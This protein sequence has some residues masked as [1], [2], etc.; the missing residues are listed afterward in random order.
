MSRWKKWA[1]LARDFFK[2]GNPGSESS[3]DV[4]LLRTEDK[5]LIVVSWEVSR[6]P[7]DTGDLCDNG[8]GCCSSSLD[9]KITH[10]KEI[11]VKM[12]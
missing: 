5:G 1:G 3:A 6:R 7:K 8:C 4:I 2:E 10:Y 9:E 12:P 11:H